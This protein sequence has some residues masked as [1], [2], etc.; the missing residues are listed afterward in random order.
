M[1]TQEVLQKFSSIVDRERCKTSKEDLL[2]YAYDACIYEF[3]PDAILFPKSAEEMAEIMKVAS[4]H[5]VFVTPRGAGSG[6]GGEA[7]AKHGGVVVCF[8]MMNRI[9]E[10]NTANRYAVL[11][12][13]VVISELQK[14]VEK[15]GLFCPRVR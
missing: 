1:L 5:N 3:V 11:E 14:A 4:A 7:L 10:I 12:P 6:L 13:G 2:T 8:T 9:L 15:L